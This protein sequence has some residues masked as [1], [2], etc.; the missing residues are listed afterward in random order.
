M[1]TCVDVAGARYPENYAGHRI[2]PLEGRSLLPT[3]EGRQRQGHPEICWEHEG[4][5]AVRQGRWKL[6][7]RYPD[8]WELY[9]LEA[10][11][12][13]MNNLADKQPTKAAELAG[14]YEQWARRCNV[15]P[16]DQVKP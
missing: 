16:W 2:T 15:V 3:L 7:S 14:K 1:A 13:E 10:D 6:V 9:D 12:T 5:R 4:N 8:H 11:R